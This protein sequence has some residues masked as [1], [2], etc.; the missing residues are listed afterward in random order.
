[1]LRPDKD[2]TK[3][4]IVFDAAAKF[5]GTS[6]NDQIYQGPKLQRDLFDVLLRLRRLPIAVVCDIEEMYL[7]IGIAHADKPYHRFLWRKVDQ[8]R[9]PD[10]YDFNR[11]VFGVNSSPFQAQFVLQH[12]AKQNQ[13]TFPMAA[14]TVLKSTYMDDSMDSVM[15]EEEGITLYHELSNLLTHAGM[16]ARK[17]LSNSQEVLKGIP[18]Q[19]RKSEVDLVTEQLPSAKTLV[20]WWIADQNMFTFRENAPDKDMKYTKRN[21]VKKI[22]TLFDPIG[23]L[24]P[25]SIRAK[26]LLQ[27]MWTAGLEWDEEM[28]ESLVKTAQ[29]WFSELHDLKWLQIPRCLQEKTTPVEDISLHTF[30]DAS[31]NAYGA[32]IY[33]RYRYKDDSLSTTIVAAKTRV[34]P[35]I[36]TSIPRLELMGAFV[37]VRLTKRISTTLD[38]P[39]STT[40]FWSDSVNVLWWVRR[41]SRQFKP[42]V[43]N[44]VG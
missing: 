9:K 40:V 15:N 32:V 23:Q 8:S 31:E 20:V 33:V 38:I 43:A 10:V 17:W 4:R 35:N 13:R 25:F 34:A 29:D 22:A 42:F 26:M 39:M 1:M 11:V 14:E 24:A 16:H 21:F 12:H 6:L 37:G 2:T 5:E 3:T 30:V 36:A 18:I 19:D 7:R 28:D 41:R 44:R 27:D